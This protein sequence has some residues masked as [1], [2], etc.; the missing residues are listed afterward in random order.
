[1][2]KPAFVF[3]FIAILLD[4][5]AIGI[6]IPVLPQLVLNFTGG[7]TAHAAQYF[8]AFGTIFAVM[9][10]VA[11][12]VMGVLSDRYGRR[13]VILVSCFGMGLDYIIMA[14]APS[15]GILFLG[16]LVSGITAA[17][18][19]TAYAYTADVTPAEKR[20]GAFA[21]IGGAFGLGFIIGPAAGGFLGAFS[22]RLP[23][24]IAAGLCIANALYGLF[25][26]PESL[27]R[28]NRSKTFE[29]KRANPIGSLRLLKTHATL[30]G[31]GA[32]MFL[33]Y[34][35]HQVFEVWVLYGHYRYAWDSKT[36]GLT[37]AIVGV[38]SSVVQMGLVQPSVSRFGE[39]RTL[40]AGLVFGALGFTLFAAATTTTIFWFGIPLICLWGLATPSIQGLMSPLVSASEQGQL[41]GALTSTRG[42]AQLIGPG[43]FT[44]TFAFFIAGGAHQLLLPGAPYYLAALI[45]AGAV[46]LAA[47]VTRGIPARRIAPPEAE[48]LGPAE[49]F[50]IE[51][52]P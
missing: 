52:A 51:D 22:L 37:L 12:P 26:L 8:G 20:A 45:I 32:V 10:F 33:A 3:I 25:V 27:G 16:R 21:L 1:M 39:R 15:L 7:D 30:V 48:A 23:F 50:P 24:W 13:P 36:V 38:C 43:L 17:S 41:Q 19:P 29:W 34:L 11:A 47:Y 14:L 18:L 49:L 46:G 4:M 6:I 40:L 35:A 31:L 9:Q 28:E 42:I 5:L 2:R 44:L